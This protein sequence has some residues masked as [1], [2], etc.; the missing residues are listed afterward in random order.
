MENVMYRVDS[1]DRFHPLSQIVT[2]LW[3]GVPGFAR[4]DS[5]EEIEIKRAL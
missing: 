5:C 1:M 3:S 4:P 2:P